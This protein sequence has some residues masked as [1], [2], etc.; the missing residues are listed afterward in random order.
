[1]KQNENLLEMLIETY[2]KKLAQLSQ[3]AI[4]VNTFSRLQWKLAEIGEVKNRLA[5]VSSDVFNRNKIL[6]DISKEVNQI[7]IE[8][9]NIGGKQS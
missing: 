4:D 6:S 3:S 1:M 7:I 2:S 8:I 5:M 9:E